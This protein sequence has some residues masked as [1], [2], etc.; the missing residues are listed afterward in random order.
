MAEAL[1]LTVP[2]PIDDLARQVL[3]LACDRD[4]K[5]ATAESCTGGL[6]ASL[7]T[8]IPGCSHAFERG[9]VVYTDAAK[10]EL[11][12]VRQSVLDIEGAVSEAAAL[13]L[14]EGALERSQA[15]VVAAITGFTDPGPSPEEEAGLVHFAAARRGGPSPSHRRMRFGAIG[16]ARVRQE[17]LQTALEMMRDE[18]LAI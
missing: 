7:L 5:L 18:I 8:D 6:L 17:A 16:R 13:A 15:D 10:H 14:A 9:F 12:G 3:R 11:L 4:L 1:A 2:A